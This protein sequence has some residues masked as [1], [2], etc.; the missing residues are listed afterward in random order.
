MYD[1]GYAMNSISDKWQF[2]RQPVLTK[3]SSLL[4]SLGYSTC[5][6]WNPNTLAVNSLDSF[7]GVANRESRPLRWRGFLHLVPSVLQID[8]FCTNSQ[9][10]KKLFS[11]FFWSKMLNKKSRRICFTAAFS[12]QQESSDS[13]SHIEN[14]CLIT[15]EEP[16][17]FRGCT[18]CADG[19]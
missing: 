1:D 2:T 7:L 19:K 10:L 9:E 14:I 8:V 15:C 3:V 5:F 13:E 12:F 6:S 16:I 17:L 18:S 11:S 4:N